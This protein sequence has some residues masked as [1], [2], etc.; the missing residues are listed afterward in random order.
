MIPRARMEHLESIYVR[1]IRADKKDKTLI[2]DDNF[3]SK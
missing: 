1:Y 3:L 2:L